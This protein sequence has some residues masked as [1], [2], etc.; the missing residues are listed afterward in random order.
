MSLGGTIGPS[1]SGGGSFSVYQ[2]VAG[3]IWAYEVADCLAT[4]ETVFSQPGYRKTARE[5]SGGLD[6]ATTALDGKSVSARATVTGD[7]IRCTEVSA[8]PSA[9]TELPWD[10]SASSDGPSIPRPFPAGKPLAVS[11]YLVP[12]PT[13]DA[14]SSGAFFCVASSPPSFGTDAPSTLVATNQYFLADSSTTLVDR[15]G[16]RRPLTAADVAS[17]NSADPSYRGV[18][19]VQAKLVQA[20]SGVFAREIQV[21]QYLAPR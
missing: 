16:H 2:P 8:T 4:T 10:T 14:E 3:R 9:P 13:V 21:A 20:Q 19:M 6:E 11:G 12:G 18:P 17:M 5:L 1:L 7:G 15:L